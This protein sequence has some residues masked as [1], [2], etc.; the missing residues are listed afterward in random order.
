MPPF[1]MPWFA[2]RVSSDRHGQRFQIIH[3]SKLLSP[4]SDCRL[5]TASTKALFLSLR[6]RHVLQWSL[7]CEM[8]YQRSR[9]H[10]IRLVYYR[11]SYQ[12]GALL[13]RSGTTGLEE[14]GI[15]VGPVDVESF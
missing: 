2:S 9:R 12:K 10:P 14:I 6:H 11:L 15:M 13:S 5:C 7:I 3:I 4:T 1:L 8:L